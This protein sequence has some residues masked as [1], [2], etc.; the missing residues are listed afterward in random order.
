MLD[1]HYY[2]ENGIVLWTC[3]R[4]ALL[5]QDKAWLESVWPQLERAAAYIT[6]LRQRSYEN[7]TPLDDG[8]NPP[9]EIDGGLSGHGTGF[10]RPEFSN[11]HWNLLGLRA[12]IQA[13]HWLGKTRLRRP[14]AEGIRRSERDV[15]PGRRAGSV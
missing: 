12:F 13:A 2:K 8:L 4:H 10:K 14:L 7:A 15:P 6:Q 11:V 9:G 3:V 1:P 5:T